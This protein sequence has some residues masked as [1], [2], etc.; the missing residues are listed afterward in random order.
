MAGSSWRRPLAPPPP[1]VSTRAGAVLRS[2]AS[3]LLWPAPTPR[4]RAP[5]SW[6]L[7][8]SPRAA[9]DH[10]DAQG[11]GA[12]QFRSMKLRHMQRV[13]DHA[14]GAL[15]SPWR[16]GHCCLPHRI[17]ASAVRECLFR[18]SIPR[19]RLPLSTLRGGPRGPAR[20]TR[21]QHD[22]LGLCC[23]TLSFTA[24]CSFSLAHL[25]VTVSAMR[26]RLTLVGKA[27]PQAA[28][29]FGGLWPRLRAAR[30]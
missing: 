3:L 15:V 2:A 12:S 24:S 18:G 23:V 29:R 11:A 17:T 6:A 25:S 1:Q 30:V 20:M 22:W 27:R 5:R 14:G 8:P 10:Q 4:H 21:G 9:R 7:R 26:R 19:L 13:C 16:P 28:G